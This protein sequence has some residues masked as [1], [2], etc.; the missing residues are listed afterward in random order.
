[1]KTWLFG[2]LAGALLTSFA[3]ESRAADWHRWDDI[4]FGVRATTFAGTQRV[5][6]GSI[7]RVRGGGLD[8]ELGVMRFFAGPLGFDF[9]LGGLPPLSDFRSIGYGK[10]EAG[11]DLGVVR[12]GGEVP[13]AL[14]VGAGV[15]GDLGKRYDYAGRIY[16]KLSARLRLAPSKAVSLFVTTEVL[17]AAF[18]PDLRVFEA[19]TE[20]GFAWKLLLIGF[21]VDHVA[22]TGGTPSRTYTQQALGLFAGI[23]LL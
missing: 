8:F 20:L 11:L 13:G 3:A 19:R 6:N 7:G 2:A 1:M 14:V 22:E 23:G 15:G 17:P 12:W 10:L 5:G 9:S 21:R 18:G 4:R 16:P